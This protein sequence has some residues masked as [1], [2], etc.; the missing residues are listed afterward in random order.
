[1]GEY[2]AAIPTEDDNYIQGELYKIR[3][4]DEF[5]YAIGQLDDYEGINPG[6]NSTSLYRRELAEVYTDNGIFSAWVFWYNGT[7]EGYPL[8]ASGDVLDYMKQR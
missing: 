1:M 4:E 8:I 5:C 7:V 6:D 2:P 3:H